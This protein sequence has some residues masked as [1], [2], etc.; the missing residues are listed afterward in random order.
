MLVHLEIILRFHVFTA[1]FTVLG[2]STTGGTSSQEPDRRSTQQNPPHRAETKTRDGVDGE[3]AFLL[4]AAGPRP[5]FSPYTTTPAPAEE[6][7]TNGEIPP[8]KEIKFSP[9]DVMKART[10]LIRLDARKLPRISQAWT[11]QNV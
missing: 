6:K 5:E 3:T 2:W 7:E 1:D 10:Q 9:E 11:R 4:T 8:I